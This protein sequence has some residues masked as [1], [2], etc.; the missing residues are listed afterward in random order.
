[1]LFNKP[2]A[3]E[4]RKK[5]AAKVPDRGFDAQLA[6]DPVFLQGFFYQ[7]ITVFLGEPNTTHL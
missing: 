1:M 7:A 3:S 4:R 2:K 6:H 5:T